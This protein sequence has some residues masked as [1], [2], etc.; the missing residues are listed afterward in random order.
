MLDMKVPQSREHAMR[1]AK[2]SAAVGEFLGMERPE[3]EQLSLAAQLHEAALFGIPTDIMLKETQ[4]SPEEGEIISMN[5]ESGL[6]MLGTVPDLEEV[7]SVF[8]FNTNILMDTACPA[9]LPTI[10]SLCMSGSSPSRARI[11]S[12]HT[13]ANCPHGYVA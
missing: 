4:L 6:T 13:S 9:D 8:A 3:L 5:L 1:T 10:R 2:Y 12:V 11:C 7:V